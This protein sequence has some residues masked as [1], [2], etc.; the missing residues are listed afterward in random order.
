[1]NVKKLIF[2]VENAISSVS[3]KNCYIASLDIKKHDN[4]IRCLIPNERLP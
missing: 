2:N 4:N 3:F 1:M